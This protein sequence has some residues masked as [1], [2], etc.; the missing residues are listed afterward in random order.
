MIEFWLAFNNGAEK[1]RL[2]VPPRDY[3]MSTGLNNTTIVNNEL[4][5]INLI[6][7]PRLKTI[8]L[9]SYFPIRYDGLCQY[10]GFPTPAECIDMI[11]R[12]RLSGKPIRLIIVGETLKVN[13]AMS[14]ESFNVS[15]RHGPQDIYF[16]LELKEYRFLSSEIDGN[17]SMDAIALLAEY[18]GSSRPM[19]KERPTAYA[20]QPGDT[21][22]GIAKRFYNN[23]SRAEELRLK[24]FLP[25][26][27]ALPAGKVIL[28]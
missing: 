13:E 7:K 20:V 22:W 10:K 19:E 15:Q 12:W 18:T 24:N 17:S 21:L 3:E 26:E 28:L 1:L 9:S 8:T 16:T 27:L 11:S 14:I 4:G 6:G 2:P 25:D 5:E 23:A